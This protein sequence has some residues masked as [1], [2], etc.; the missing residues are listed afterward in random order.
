MG[1]ASVEELIVVALG[2][3]DSALVF[4]AELHLIVAAVAEWGEEG[5]VVT[6]QDVSG[7][8]E[9]MDGSGASRA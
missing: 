6:E 4:T 7:V 5:E 8:R 1:D 3:G 2:T 9:V